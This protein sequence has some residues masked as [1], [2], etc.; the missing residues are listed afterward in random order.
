MS[1]QNEGS[2]AF[3]AKPSTPTQGW[4]HD[5][6]GYRF[7]PISQQGI[8]IWPAKRPD[9][10][11]ELVIQGPLGNSYNIRSAIPSCGP[12]GLFVAIT[13]KDALVLYLNA[14]AVE[15]FASPAENEPIETHDFSLVFS[16]FHA[17]IEV[18]A[19]IG[20]TFS[21][22]VTQDVVGVVVSPNLTHY[23]DTSSITIGEKDP[24]KI[25]VRQLT[26]WTGTDDTRRLVFDQG[27]GRTWFFNLEQKKYS[28]TLLKVGSVTEDGQTFRSYDFRLTCLK[29]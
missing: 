16:P 21:M 27:M 3:W 26:A 5:K 22:P 11:I 24:L 18:P 9:K 10:T 6:N 2:V 4:E 12:N 23:E 19:G 17:P 15:V 1:I 25:S 7:P 20:F 28:A 13:W 29:S 8:S 14:Q